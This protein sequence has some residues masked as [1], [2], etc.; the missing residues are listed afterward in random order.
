MISEQKE[1]EGKESVLEHQSIQYSSI[2]CNS[3]L[4]FNA[5]YH[6]H[7][8]S[9]PLKAGHMA[10]TGPSDFLLKHSIST[11]NI[12]VISKLKT[13]S[14]LSFSGSKL[15]KRIKFLYKVKG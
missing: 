3:N 10:T 5:L 15:A 2:I 12:M 8:T 11:N 7:N 6:N 9:K 14:V 4:P 13:S 1:K